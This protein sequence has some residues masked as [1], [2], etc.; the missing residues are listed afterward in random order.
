RIAGAAVLAVVAVAPWLVPWQQ[1]P[2]TSAEETAPA[3]VL[4]GPGPSSPRPPAQPRPDVDDVRELGE[5][6]AAA[7]GYD[8]PVTPEE[9]AALSTTP[10]E[11]QE[12]GRVQVPAIGLDAA[13]GEGVH[14][15]VLAEGP[16][17]WPGT[18]MPGQ[19]GNAV[20]S[21]HRNTHTQ[22]F[23]ELDELEPGDAVVVS[24]AG[25]STTYEVTGTTIVPEEEY[26]DAVLAQPE[27]GTREVTLFACHP[28]GD[29][30]YRIVVRAEAR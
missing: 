11:H 15:S 13:Y 22:P 29:P 4:P 9:L 28:E 3:R 18:P 21:G 26:K 1:L 19:E 27:P 24:T 14:E 16:G 25:G 12:L 10:G 5:V 2:G 30:V 20:I 7:T 23:K 17:H 6:V 8:L